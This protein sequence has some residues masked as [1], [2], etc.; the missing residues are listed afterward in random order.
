MFNKLS[1]SI[2][3]PNVLTKLDQTCNNKVNV[4]DI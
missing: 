3:G 2:L 4:L 1:F